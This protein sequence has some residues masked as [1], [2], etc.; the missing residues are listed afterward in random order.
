MT[1]RITSLFG[2]AL[3]FT[4]LTFAVYAGSTATF[5]PSAHGDE[6][7]SADEILHHLA[8]APSRKPPRRLKTRGSQSNRRRAPRGFGGSPCRPS[9]SSSTLTG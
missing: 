1:F 2:S 4:G 9:G 6:I 5:V 7:L 3:A 8:P